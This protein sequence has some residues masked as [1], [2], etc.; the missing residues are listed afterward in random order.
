MVKVLDRLLLVLYSLAVLLVSL[1]VLTAA[2]GLISFNQAGNF[3]HDVY[4][5]L[6]TALVFISATVIIALL[7]IRF[8]Y[9]SLRRGRAA[10]PSIDQ[11]NEF[12]D[13]RISLETV[14]NLSL[15]AANRTR[16][17][18]DLRSRVRVNQAG[19]ELEIRAIVEG[20]SP[21]PQLTEEMQSNVKQHIEDITGIPVASVTV[22][23]ANIAPS[24]PTFK[25]RVE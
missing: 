13:I 12:G 14:E 10:V 15:K 8:L 11:R 2:F 23:I 6:D 3:A 21:I 17:V 18:R 24:S 20:D 7:S 4:Y 19:L 1:V 25:S 22:F 9:I 16:G 5:D